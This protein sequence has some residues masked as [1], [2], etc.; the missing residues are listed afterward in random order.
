MLHEKLWTSNLD[1]AAACLRHPFVSALRGG[2]LEAGL[3]SGYV[4]QDAFSFGPFSRLT[5]WRWSGRMTL[6][7]SVIFTP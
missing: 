6:R 2:T 1:L 5:R 3:F 7:A 4:A